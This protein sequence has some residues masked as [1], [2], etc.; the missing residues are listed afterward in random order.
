MTRKEW[1]KRGQEQAPFVIRPMERPIKIPAAPPVSSGATPKPTCTDCGST[2]RK[3]TQVSPK[4]LLCATDI[5]LRRNAK[6][7]QGRSRWS[8]QTYGI[9]LEEKERV[10]QFQGGGCICRPWTGYNGNSRNLSTDHDH[11]TGLIRGELCKHCNDLLGRV[12]D[13][14][15]YF[16]A[17][18]AYLKLPPAE[19]VLG[20]RY[21]PEG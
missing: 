18:I 6:R 1:P 8:V 3:L 2:I 5:R 15:A 9:T 13:D 16:H 17:M 21:A 10:K 4:A 7:L 19:R 14:P 11:A 12:R 20:K